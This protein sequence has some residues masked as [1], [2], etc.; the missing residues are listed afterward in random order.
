MNPDLLLGRVLQD[1]FEILSI[2]GSGG[3]GTVFRARQLD[4]DRTVAVKVLGATLLDDEELV[5]RFQREA[6]AIS[7]LSHIHIASFYSYGLLDQKLPY[8]VMEFLEATCLSDL[9]DKE[10]RL[11]WK[12]ALNIIL[13]VCDALAYAH[14]A[15]IVHRDLKPANIMLQESPEPDFVKL[16]DFG[17]A[18]FQENVSASL[19]MKLTQ[20]GEI[21]G[22]P[23]FM[24]P[25]QCMAKKAD[26]RSDIYALGLIL[27]ALVTGA[28]PFY[29]EDPI[30]VFSKQIKEAPLPPSRKPALELPAGFDFVVLKCLDKDPDQR[31]QSAEE[32]MEA[33]NT[34]LAG[35]G[36]EMLKAEKKDSSRL[37]TLSSKKL[38]VILALALVFCTLGGFF[39]FQSEQGKVLEAY[40]SMNSDPSKANALRLLE[41]AEKLPERSF[42]SVFTKLMQIIGQSLKL[43]ELSLIQRQNLYIEF[44]QELF[45]KRCNRVAR[46][47]VL[48]AASELMRTIRKSEGGIDE[49]VKPYDKLAGLLFHSNCKLSQEQLKQFEQSTVE[50]RDK[51]ENQDCDAALLMLASQYE[52]KEKQASPDILDCLFALDRILA[53][54]HKTET[55]D[56]IAEQTKAVAKVVNADYQLKLAMHYTDLA[57]ILLEVDEKSGAGRYLSKAVSELQKKADS[58]A[59][60]YS[61]REAFLPYMAKLARGYAH[62][63]ELKRAEGLVTMFASVFDKDDR[64]G[65]L[66]FDSQMLMAL[67]NHYSLEKVLQ[68]AKDN[69]LKA[70]AFSAN[71]DDSRL[72][73]SIETRLSCASVYIQILKEQ[74]KLEEAVK[75]YKNELAFLNRLLPQ[76]W[77]YCESLSKDLRLTYEVSGRFSDAEK[78]M[79]DLKLAA[80]KNRIAFPYARQIEII[81][82]GTLSKNSALVAKAI[83]ELEKFPEW[84]DSEILKNYLW[85]LSH[86][87]FLVK[88]KNETAAYQV[89]LE[90]LYRGCRERMQLTKGQDP[91]GIAL[92]C[93]LYRQLG[94]KKMETDLGLLASKTLKRRPLQVYKI[95]NLIYLAEEQEQN[96]EFQQA[97]ELAKNAKELSGGE[98]SYQ[99]VIAESTLARVLLETR[100]YQESL[101]LARPAYLK[102]TQLSSDDGKKCRRLC[103]GL[104]YRLWQ[105][106]SNTGD[107]SAELLGFMDKEL[108]FQRHF[109]RFNELHET[110]RDKHEILKA[111]SHY[112][113]ACNCL[114]EARRIAEKERDFCLAFDDDLLILKLA[115]L[116]DNGKLIYNTL[117]RLASYNNLKRPDRLFTSWPV[118]KDCLEYLSRRRD[119]E[120]LAL[121]RNYL[122]RNYGDY[123]SLPVSRVNPEFLAELYIT[124]FSLNNEDFANELRKQALIKLPSTNGRRLLA[125]TELKKSVYLRVLG[126]SKESLLSASDAQKNL[127]EK[128]T[129]LEAQI[130]VAMAHGLL[131]EGRL[132]A[133]QKNLEA[134]S[135]IFRRLHVFDSDCV[136][137]MTYALLREKRFDDAAKYLDAELELARR[138]PQGEWQKLFWTINLK[139]ELENARGQRQ[140]AIAAA[141]ECLELAKVHTNEEMQFIARMHLLM[142]GVRTNDRALLDNLKVLLELKQAACGQQLKSFALDFREALLYFK[143]EKQE[144]N[145]LIVLK[146]VKRGYKEILE[147]L[148]P[149]PVFLA[150]ILNSLRGDFHENALAAGLETEALKIL[151]KKDRDLFTATLIK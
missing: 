50:L 125:L 21:L 26:S 83:L 1:R 119:Q 126:K 4:L 131:V 113:A 59:L 136:S 149:D 23:L 24:S 91:E 78:T 105:A 65:R 30:T 64:A 34:V 147:S 85:V 29:A 74:N 112:D 114:M 49:L 46:K 106:A 11:H 33:I 66:R 92:A 8:I 111:K 37:K 71:L 96:R 150:R 117:S 109:S 139:R 3:M 140:L 16:V 28:P 134:A 67:Q 43:Q 77:P 38:F 138:L 56:K 129:L 70:A 107:W 63:K 82:D 84:K 116:E 93:R 68:E 90:M 86:A 143:K 95:W 69:Y 145:Y 2:A 42:D 41:S 148:H 130:L 118:I 10:Q 124:L 72:T 128:S 32:L 17:L 14:K 132:Q 135:L 13:Q 76:S 53:A 110:L 79:L 18:G 54:R 61:Q 146:L 121:A 127:D 142:F 48:R 97:L 88:E 101:E 94:E 103:L 51:L 62:L 133:T 36:R 81:N 122:I 44:S 47:L 58:A 75:I 12:R 98:F 5:L 40:F 104:L 60:S 87:A 6:K 137:L 115:M 57:C 7:R 35:R 27:Y 120:G 123:L 151:E 45:S 22:T 9:I 19:Q 108:E 99:A 31:Y 144:E 55:L 80:K 20:T 15:G 52:F 89:F 73:E 25:E 100:R 102:A 39:I 141:N